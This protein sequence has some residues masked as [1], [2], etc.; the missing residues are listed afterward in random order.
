MVFLRESL[1]TDA[2]ILLDQPPF[3]YFQSDQKMFERILGPTTQTV[4]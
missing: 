4:E 2:T 3:D 1:A